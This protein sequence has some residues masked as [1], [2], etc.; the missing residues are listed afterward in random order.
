MKEVILKKRC[1]KYFVVVY[2]DLKHEFT[3]FRHHSGTLRAAAVCLTIRR[4][5]L[6][7]LSLK[8]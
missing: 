7:L 3:S 8:I 4:K 6:L 1:V 2:E 5:F